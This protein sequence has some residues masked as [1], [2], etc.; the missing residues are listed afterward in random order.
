MALDSWNWF[1]QLAQKGNFT[2]AAEELGISQQT[3]SARLASLERELDAK[4]IVRSTPLTLTPAGTEF[5]A[6]AA[7][8]EQA[9]AE[10]V[11][12]VGEASSGGAGV[13]KVAIGNMRAWSMMPAVIT[14][15]R[16]GLPGVRVELIEGTNEDLLRMAE[17]G[18]VDIV[19]ARF[20]R[21][22]PGVTARP[23]FEEEVVVAIDPA[24]LERT[25]GCPAQEA[26]R[27]VESEGLALLRECPFLLEDDDDIAGRIG[28]TEM[29]KAGIKQEGVVKAES[30]TV[31]LALCRQG[32]GAVFSPLTLLDAAQDGAQLLRIHLPEPARYQISVGRPANAEPWT[33]AQT[34]EDIIGA[35]FGD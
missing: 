9:R 29:K 1:I 15:F 12:R 11:R 33:P 14:E 22:H 20:D 35:L 16:K 25:V 2:R 31:L 24:L 7:E 28:Q 8:Q 32:L 10:L 34:F 6:Y 17:R 30:M 18:E 27:R 19:V 13:L 21:S 3:L 26:V 23:L 4:L 5:L